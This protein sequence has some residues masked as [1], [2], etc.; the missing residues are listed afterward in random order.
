MNQKEEEIP[1]N[2]QINKDEYMFFPLTGIFSDK[3]KN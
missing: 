2:E 3:D 1:I